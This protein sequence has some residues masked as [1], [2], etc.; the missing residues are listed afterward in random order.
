MKKRNP[1]FAAIM[2]LITF[3]I[4][5]IYWLITTRRELVQRGA[6]IPTLWLIFA[7]LLGLILVIFLQFGLR[8]ALGGNNDSTLTSIA[9]I[10]SVLIGIISIIGL[11]PAFIYWFYKYSKG[12]EM[13]TRDQTSFNFCFWWGFV[14]SIVGLDFVWT[15]IIQNRFNKQVV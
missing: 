5:K 1:W 10:L 15:G 4:Y 9:N 7:P 8:F 13:V 14:M 12:V 6:Q 3:G 11:V 2:A